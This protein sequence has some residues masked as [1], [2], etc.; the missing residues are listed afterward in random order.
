MEYINTDKEISLAQGVPKRPLMSR[1]FS[2]I[3]L[4]ISVDSQIFIHR[5]AL[6]FSREREK[7]SN[8]LT[9]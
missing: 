2:E 9:F 5:R 3:K 8:K 4:L 7:S 1:W 6:I